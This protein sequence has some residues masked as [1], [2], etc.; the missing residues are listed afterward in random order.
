MK[1]LT[2]TLTVSFRLHFLFWALLV[3]LCQLMIT[4][5]SDKSEDKKSCGDGTESQ[6]FVRNDI[7][8]DQNYLTYW[9]YPSTGNAQ[10]K[11]TLM[12]NNCCPDQPV[13]TQIG[14][15]VPMLPDTMLYIRARLNWGQGDSKLFQLQQTGA[16]VN[17][18][19]WFGWLDINLKEAYNNSEGKFN[20]EIEFLFPSKGTEQENWNYYFNVLQPTLLF[21]YAFYPYHV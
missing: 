16:G 13:Y 8:V 14:V 11:C 20:L 17:R 2:K 5:C 1:T 19:S 6:E 4:A 21:A 15:K 9:Y 3:G 18:V 10:V 7:I 12:F